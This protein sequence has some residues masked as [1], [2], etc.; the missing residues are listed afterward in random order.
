MA[1]CRSMFPRLDPVHVDKNVESR[2]TAR[3]KDIPEE[4]NNT[5]FSGIFSRHKI[6]C[7]HALNENFFIL[8]LYTND[9]SRIAQSFAFGPSKVGNNR[10]RISF[11]ASLSQKLIR[12]LL[13][14][15]LTMLN[16]ILYT[17]FIVSNLSKQATGNSRK[18]PN[19]PILINHIRDPPP[20]IHDL[21]PT[22]PIEILTA[23][24]AGT[25]IPGPTIRIRAIFENRR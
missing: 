2:R 21:T 19:S 9:C 14:P 25:Q 23:Q 22:V 16:W 8:L 15:L 1:G 11:A 24:L 17:A 18:S 20:L 7:K 4:K 13:R 5:P 6:P 3:S 10:S 12:S